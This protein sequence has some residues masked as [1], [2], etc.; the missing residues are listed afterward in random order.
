[1]SKPTTPGPGVYV[2]EATDCHAFSRIPV[3]VT[4]ES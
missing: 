4:L 3:S 1:M 2:H